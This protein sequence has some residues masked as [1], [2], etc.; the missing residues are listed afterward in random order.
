MTLINLIIC[1][2]FIGGPWS[3][4]DGLYLSNN[5]SQHFT[6]FTK[7]YS[8]HSEEKGG[9]IGCLETTMRVEWVRFLASSFL[10]SIPI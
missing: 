2:K 8:R 6:D 5:F 10:F 9:N 1:N 7:K 3:L 4:M